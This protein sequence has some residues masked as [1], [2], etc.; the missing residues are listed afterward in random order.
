[1]HTNNRMKQVCLVSPVSIREIDARLEALSVHREGRAI[2][3]RKAVFYTFR[4]TSLSAPAANILKQEAL[5]AGAELATAWSVIK[6]PDTISDALLMGTYRQ[7][8]LIMDKIASQQFGLP[9][10]AD[11]LRTALDNLFQEHRTLRCRATTLDFSGRPKLMGILNVTPDSF[12]DGGLFFSPEAAVEHGLA[13]CGEGAD[14]LDIGGES[15]KPGSAPV[16]AEEE[17]RRIIPVIRELR[18]RVGI[19]L[20]VDTTKAAVAAEALENGADIVNDISAM[21]IDPGMSG[22]VKKFGA[23]VVLMHMQGTP[24]TMQSNPSYTDVVLE[25]LS[26]LEERARYA[27]SEAGID[28]ECIAV[29]PGIGFGKTIDHNL[30]L[31]KDIRAFRTLGFPVLAG[32]S[33]KSF[34]GRLTG[35]DTGERVPG[36]LATAVWAATHGV[37]IIRVHDIRETKQALSMINHILDA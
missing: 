2:M 29:D 17:K 26:Y 18:K 34:I 4:I 31:L 15:T 19:P 12:S 14:L 9:A 3:N 13:L 11:E 1:M 16:S 35:T 24:A 8:G 28:R 32:T 10:I 36:S 30:A 7:I 5:A 33:R 20:S 23:G 22:V 27:I 6:A 21:T 37:D 25:V